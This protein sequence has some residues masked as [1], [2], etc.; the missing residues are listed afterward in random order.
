MFYNVYME[1]FNLGL[2]FILGTI[3]GSF[4]NVVIY[5]LGTGFSIHKGRSRC[6]SCNK[7]LAWYELIPIVSFLLQ[8]GR[9]KTCRTHLSLQYPLVE[10]FTGVLFVFSAYI[11]TFDIS[12]I[13]L[14]TLITFCF[15]AVVSSLLVVLFVYDLKHKI[16]PSSILYSFVIISFVY[17]FFLYVGDERTAFDIFSGIILAAPIFILWL[18]SKGKWIG[19][20]DGT[21]FLGVGFLLGFVMGIH[22]FLFSFWIGALVALILTYLLPRRFSFGSEI[23]FG[24]FIIL[25]TLF[26]LFIQSDIL[27]VSLFYDL[28]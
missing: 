26:F 15:Y 5:R 27:G 3:I 1:F 11:T 12:Q 9:C 6:F 23:P 19:F 4:L 20:A 13:S 7:T 14:E 28:F 21:L 10:F 22:A 24:P 17:T 8:K 25:S 16:L 2:I 18:V